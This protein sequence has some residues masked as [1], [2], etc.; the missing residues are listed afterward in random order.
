[1]SCR[2]FDAGRLSRGEYG[3]EIEAVLEM[4]GQRVERRLDLVLIGNLAALGSERGEKGTPEQ[5]AGRARED[6]IR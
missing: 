2:P 6:S 3:G 4:I 1:M 5:V